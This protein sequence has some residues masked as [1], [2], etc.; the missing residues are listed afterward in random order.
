MPCCPVE[1]IC[2]DLQPQA[3]GYVAVST[4]RRSLK[5]V[6]A[7]ASQ[8]YTASASCRFRRFLRIQLHFIHS[9]HTARDPL[10]HHA[11]HPLRRYFVVCLYPDVSKIF[12][13]CT[14][15]Q[16]HSLRT[17]TTPLLIST[18][19]TVLR[20]TTVRPS[21]TPITHSPVGRKSILVLL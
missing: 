19:M 10:P 14:Y 1:S 5:E 3:Q 4:T 21:T 17:Y 11:T 20:P 8:R 6:S 2:G 12:F 7:D 15:R 9:M 16:I 18:S 13:P